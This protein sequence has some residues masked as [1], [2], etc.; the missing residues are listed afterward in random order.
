MVLKE[1]ILV[2]ADRCGVKFIK[3]FHLYRGWN[4]KCSHIGDFLKISVRKTVPSNW[5]KKKT[6][7]KAFILRT[8]FKTT[9]N[10]GSSFNFKENN[11]VL[12][13]KRLTTKGKEIWGP[14]IK[15]IKRRKF[16]AS[17]VGYL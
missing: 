7:L 8:K 4:R 14:S 17:L 13:K 15:K 11:A 5:I 1:S 2:P 3:V 10:D 16:L 6:K 9:N 12:L